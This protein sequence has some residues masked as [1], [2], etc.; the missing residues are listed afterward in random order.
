M[1]RKRASSSINAGLIYA[2]IA[3]GLFG[4]TFLAAIIY[5]G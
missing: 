1:D 2:G 3:V 5:I 4:L